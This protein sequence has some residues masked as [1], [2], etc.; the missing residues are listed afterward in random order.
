[1]A[2]SAGSAAPAGKAHKIDALMEQASAALVKEK[3]FDCERLC[4]E[5]LRAAHAA[6]DYDRIARIMMPLEECR[7]QRRL[8]ALDT[9]RVIQV[10]AV[11]DLAKLNPGCYLLCA[12]GC[13]GADGRALRELAIERRIPIAVVVHEPLTR[14]G[15]LPLVAVGPTTVRVREKPPEEFCTE[16]FAAALEALGEEAMAGIEWEGPGA[17]RVNQLLE[18]LE[19]VPE[20]DL[21]HQKIVE[22]CR[23]AE[24]E[25]AAERERKN[26]ARPA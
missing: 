14:T 6:R 18:A 19:T 13:V 2:K 20:C 16:W 24:Q 5:A 22:A 8:E 9:G 11:D 21:I 4:M 12:P 7:R 10:K 15:L 17:T 26:A 23:D 1:M 3:H 25:A